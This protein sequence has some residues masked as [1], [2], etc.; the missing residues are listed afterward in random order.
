[1]TDR[2]I[3]G[4]PTALEQARYGVWDSLCALTPY[5]YVQAIQR[6]GGMVLMIPED[7]AVVEDPGPVLDRIDA[8]LLAGG[9]DI[10][11][12]AYGS[13]RDPH[14]VN[15]VPARDELELAL[16]REALA[17]DLPVLGICRGMQLL[18][19][20]TGGTLI[21]HVPDVAGNDEHR[22]NAGTFDGNEHPVELEPGSLAAEAAGEQR[23]RTFSH[24]HQAVAQVGNGLVVTGRAD[25]GLIEAIEDPERGYV[26]GVQWHPEADE[27]SQVVGSLVARAREYR[28]A[29]T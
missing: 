12:Q 17:R 24:H 8:L 27:A 1:M 2:P 25:D 10:D 19:I 23:H 13:E 5:S 7:P 28:A 3:I 22:R 20:A 15:T 9:C 16:T 21:Q 4:I 29:R 6:A 14:T 11:P 18:N 26:L